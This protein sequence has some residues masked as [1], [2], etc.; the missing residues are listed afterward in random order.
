MNTL[1]SIERGCTV[2]VQKSNFSYYFLTVFLR[3][4]IT[5]PFEKD[6][7]LLDIR[8]NWLQVKSSV[9]SLLICLLS[10]FWTT[11]RHLWCHKVRYLWCHKVRYLWCH[12]VCYLWCHKVRYLWCHKV[13]YL[14]CQTCICNTYSHSFSRQL[15]LTSPLRHLRRPQRAG[16]TTTEHLVRL[17]QHPA[18]TL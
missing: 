2:L 1:G 10:V 11:V 9:S 14:W 18:R 13:R 5:W 7:S 8:L 3:V 16:R 17:P 6:L 4:L 12:K 15:S